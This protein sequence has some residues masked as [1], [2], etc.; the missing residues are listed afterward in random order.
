MHGCELLL[1]ARKKAVENGL[2]VERVNRMVKLCCPE[3]N[4]KGDENRCPILRS[5]RREGAYNNQSISQRR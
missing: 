3:C 1:K 5:E 4:C 2:E